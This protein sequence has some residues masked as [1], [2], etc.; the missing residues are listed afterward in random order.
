MLKP[1]FGK[2]KNALKQ[3]NF[4]SYNLI[5]SLNQN[6]Q[7]SLAR[8]LSIIFSAGSFLFLYLLQIRQAK[9]QLLSVFYGWRWR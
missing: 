6:W 1:S 9:E 8:A 3:K 7:W 5:S 4:P 2:L